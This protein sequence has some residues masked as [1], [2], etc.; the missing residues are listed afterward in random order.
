LP[1]LAHD[2]VIV[3]FD[4]SLTFGTGAQ[5][6]KSYPAVLGK[7]VDRRVVNAGYPGEMTSQGLSHLPIILDREK[8]ALLLL[9]LGVNDQ[10]LNINQ[11]KVANNIKEMIQLAWKRE[12]PVVLIAVPDL[13]PSPSRPPMYRKI[14][15]EF[16]IPIEEEV[17]SAILAADSTLKADK[18]HP[19]AA[20]YRLM[21]E[22]I[23]SLLHRSGA[24]K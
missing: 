6:M 3:A 4:D 2:S 11:Q 5:P 20:G 15:R 16:C 18:V 1:L 19:N 22:S 23:A 24:R 8:P 21:A 9:C 12:V 14:A 7:N 13:E 10:L 17:L